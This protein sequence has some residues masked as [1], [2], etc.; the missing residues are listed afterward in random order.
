MYLQSKRGVYVGIFLKAALKFALSF[1]RTV[2][3]DGK[4]LKMFIPA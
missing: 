4:P 1:L 3:F 2:K